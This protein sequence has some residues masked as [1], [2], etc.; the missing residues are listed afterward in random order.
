MRQLSLEQ[1]S[2]N[3]SSTSYNVVVLPSLP[4]PLPPP[5]LVN[6]AVIRFAAAFSVR[7]L[8]EQKEQK[9]TD[10]AISLTVLSFQVGQANRK[11]PYRPFRPGEGQLAGGEHRDGRGGHAALHVWTLVSLARVKRFYGSEEARSLRD[12]GGHSL[13]RRKLLQVSQ[14]DAI[15]VAHSVHLCS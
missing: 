13:L 12:Y 6:T 4:P 8:E 10:D 9:Q 7:T 2:L 11:P 5:S 15:F 1:P 14:P 3:L